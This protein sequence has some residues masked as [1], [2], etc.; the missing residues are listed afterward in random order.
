MQPRLRIVAQSPGGFMAGTIGVTGA[1]SML[2]Y[3]EQTTGIPLAP[4]MLFRHA[5]H[6]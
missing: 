5:A 4:E 2:W 1:G 6:S 3:C